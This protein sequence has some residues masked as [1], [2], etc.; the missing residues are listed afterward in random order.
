MVDLSSFLECRI[1][2]DRRL[3]DSLKEATA[4]SDDAYALGV[5]FASRLL[6]ESAAKQ[7][8]LDRWRDDAGSEVLAH[9]VRDLCTA[10]ATHADYRLDWQL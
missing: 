3:A 4:I 9:V 7:R 1:A 5:T 2:D 10:Y 8:V 6:A